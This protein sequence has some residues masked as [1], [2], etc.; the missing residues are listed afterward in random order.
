MRGNSTLSLEFA[1]ATDIG[2]VRA[3]NEDSFGY[4]AERQIY[5]VCDGMGGSAGGEVASNLAV[6]VLIESLESQEFAATPGEPATAIEERL[7]R[8]IYAANES[9]REAAAVNPS[10]KSMGTTLVCL[11]M[12]G[13][14]A[15]VA[16]V[17]DSR[18]Y[19]VRN[20][21]CQQITQDHTW[22]EEQ[23]R[24]GLLT[25]EMASAPA[26]QSVIT[27]A[28]GA[29]E[30][31]VPDFFAAELRPN[32]LI[33]LASDGLTRYA[34]QEEIESAVSL[35]GDLTALCG[36]LIEHAKQCGG[37]DNVTCITLRAVE[38]P[39][40]DAGIAEA[41]VHD[42]AGSPAEAITGDLPFDMAGLREFC[43]ERPCGSAA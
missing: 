31:V 16:N 3:N 28:I 39:L 34:T 2:C 17:G 1:A 19:L 5:V 13:A 18:A 25:P 20:G 8:A 37:V 29:T 27:R 33:L 7:L 43:G 4:D 32:D 42:L 14:R 10:L 40:M 11:C 24:S 23:R 30:T 35:G 22:I 38:I 41:Q 12:D 36:A 9:V 15:V 21:V 6:R 26:L